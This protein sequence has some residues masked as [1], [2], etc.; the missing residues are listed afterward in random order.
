MT[1]GIT[2]EDIERIDEIVDE[3]LLKQGDIRDY[4][5]KQKKPMKDE[6]GKIMRDEDGNIIYEKVFSEKAVKAFA[7]K[8]AEKRGER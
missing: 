1:D 2:D 4:L 6:N 3:E 7:K 8:V 5:R